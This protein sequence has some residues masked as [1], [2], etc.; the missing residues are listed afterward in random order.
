MTGESLPE[1]SKGA[2]AAE[3][4]DDDEDM[5]NQYVE[6]FK[7]DKL[8]EIQRKAL[9]CLL[10]AFKTEI[11]T[12]T[13]KRTEIIEKLMKEWNIT[14]KAKTSSDN[15]QK[16][17]LAN[18]QRLYMDVS[19]STQIVE[20]RPHIL[21]QE[22]KETPIQTLAVS[23]SRWGSVDPESLVGQFVRVRMLD[24]VGFED[25]LIREYDAEQ[26]KHRLETVGSDAMGSDPMFSWMDV[27][28]VQPKHIMWP[29][30][31][32]PNFGDAPKPKWNSRSKHR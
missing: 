9:S 29:A 7:K 18:K 11:P 4:S 2:D 13:D 1:S 23:T 15:I 10:L 20:A 31:E 24:D 17:L 32:R 3:H 6:E 8:E 26:E 21:S 5:V 12:L 27:R 25:F 28:D 16:H 22:E 14:H 19:S 30:G